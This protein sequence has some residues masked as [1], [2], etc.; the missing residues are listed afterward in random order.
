MKDY[1]IF[2]EQQLANLLS[3]EE[4]NLELINS[5]IDSL[6]DNIGPFNETQETSLHHWCKRKSEIERTI[7]EIKKAIRGKSSGKIVIEYEGM[8]LSV[9][10]FLSL[11]LQ[12]CGGGVLPAA[13]AAT[14]CLIS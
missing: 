3:Q 4:Q 1:T 14:G 9:I 10:R 8:D 12:S 6:Y 2:N 5:S 7:A 13:V 11:I